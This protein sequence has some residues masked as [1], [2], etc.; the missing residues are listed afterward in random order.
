MSPVRMAQPMLEESI[1]ALSGR[2][3]TPF[4]PLRELQFL[5]LYLGIAF[6][7]LTLAAYLSQAALGYRKLA[8]RLAKLALSWPR[9]RLA[10]LVEEA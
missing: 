8:D 10:T 9:S 4:V 6:R 7:N 5:A 2:S 1:A 3:P